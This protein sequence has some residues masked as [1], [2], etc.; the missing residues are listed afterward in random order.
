M[1]REGAA[2]WG[3]AQGEASEAFA[4]SAKFKGG[5]GNSAIK[6]KTILMQY[7]F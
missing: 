4:S 6:R 3:R 7:L 5:A 2:Q 1:G